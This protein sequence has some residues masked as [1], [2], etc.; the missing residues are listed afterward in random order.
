MGS[1]KNKSEQDGD[2]HSISHHV[3]GGNAGGRFQTLHLRAGVIALSLLFIPALVWGVGALESKQPG[4]C[5]GRHWN[6]TQEYLDCKFPKPPIGRW[7]AVYTEGFAKEHNLP[8]ENISTDISDGVDYMEMDVQPYADGLTA[9]LVN[10]LIKKPNDMAVY[11][12]NL[13]KNWEKKFHAQRKLAHL[14]D[15]EE[16]KDNLREIATFGLTSRGDTYDPKRSYTIGSSIAFYGGEVLGE[17]D[18]VSANA[19]CYHLISKEKLFPDGFAFT[20]A[21]ASVWGREKY[22]FSSLDDPRRPRG[23]AYFDSRVYINIPQE[24]VA[25]IMKDMPIGGR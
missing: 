17:Y 8:P 6:N 1:A 11:S 16:Y 22:R 18:Y 7:H 23:K 2:S 20:Y 10:M 3:T 21:K 4:P 24:L 12:G 15:L 13:A 25:N 14:I 19:D 9:C 5:D